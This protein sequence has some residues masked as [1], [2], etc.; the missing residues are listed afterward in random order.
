MNK[1]DELIKTALMDKMTNNVNIYTA[2]DIL[3]VANISEEEVKNF[4]EKIMIEINE[5]TK[6]K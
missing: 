4:Q 1:R 3:T 6:K 2:Y 5:L